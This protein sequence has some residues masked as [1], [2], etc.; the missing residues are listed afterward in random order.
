MINYNI[1]VDLSWTMTYISAEF[2]LYK[3]DSHGSIINAEE[4]LGMR[5]I[6]EA[7]KLLRKVENGTVA[8]TA[9]NNP[10]EYLKKWLLNLKGR[11]I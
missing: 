4:V 3:F 8:P 7:I 9:Y 1:V 10:F 11:L 6:E 2:A 5:P